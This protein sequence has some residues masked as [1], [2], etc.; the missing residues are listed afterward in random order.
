[1][2]CF[3]KDLDNN[4]ASQIFL[5]RPGHYLNNHFIIGDGVF[6]SDIINAN[7]LKKTL[8][9]RLNKPAVPLF[10]QRSNEFIAASLK[11]LFNAAARYA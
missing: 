2:P 11:D 4:S 5:R 3:S 9:V 8:T 1:M 6:C 7:K 10:Q